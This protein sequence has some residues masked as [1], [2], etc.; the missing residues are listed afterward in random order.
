MGRMRLI[1]RRC[2][3]STGR[4]RGGLEGGVVRS[5][6]RR[7]SWWRKGGVGVDWERILSCCQVPEG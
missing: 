7:I 3:G 2:L 6:C 4:R 1:G 5:S